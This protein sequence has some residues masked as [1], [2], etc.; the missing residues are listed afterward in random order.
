[1]NRI[2]ILLLVLIFSNFIFSVYE[3]NAGGL[4]G[5]AC[6][7]LTTAAYLLLLKDKGE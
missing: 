2:Y 7:G 5:W 6:A 1:M 4:F 3:G